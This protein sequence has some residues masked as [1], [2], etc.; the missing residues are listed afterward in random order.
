MRAALSPWRRRPSVASNKMP[1]SALQDGCGTVGSRLSFAVLPSPSSATVLIVHHHQLSILCCTVV[2]VPQY[3]ED[4][5]LLRDF[6]A[7]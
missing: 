7:R 4:T 2:E 1:D 3:Q 5:S 6:V